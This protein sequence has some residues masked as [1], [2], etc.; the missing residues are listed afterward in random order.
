MRQNKVL[1]STLKQTLLNET[2]INGTHAVF[3]N[4]KIYSFCKKLFVILLNSLLRLQIDLGIPHADG[5]VKSLFSR[6]L[7][8]N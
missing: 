4:M 1:L 8:K 2:K 6:Y 7:V 3:Y 5:R